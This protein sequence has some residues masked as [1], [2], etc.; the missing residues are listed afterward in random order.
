MID[1]LPSLQIRIMRLRFIHCVTSLLLLCFISHAPANEVIDAAEAAF[2]KASKKC[3]EAFA[4][5]VEPLPV[6]LREQWEAVHGQWWRTSRQEADLIASVTSGGGS[7]YTV[8]YLSELTELLSERAK[9][10]SA[11]GRRFRA[12]SGDDVAK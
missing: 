2:E 9:F 5:L 8:D 11:V 10:Y 12:T 3:D 1:D 7:A 4:Q 6:K